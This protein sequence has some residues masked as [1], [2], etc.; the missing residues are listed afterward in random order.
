MVFDPVSAIGL[1][2]TLVQLIDFGRKLLCESHQIHASPT[3]VSSR[4]EELENAAQTLLSLDGNVEHSLQSKG[5]ATSAND[6]ELRRLGQNCHL[7]SLEL[8][9]TLDKLRVAGSKHRKWRSFQQ[10][11][12]SVLS[13]DEIND[14]L[15]RMQESR[16]QLDSHMLACLR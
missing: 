14:L 5:R 4:N 11:F 13:N 8:L 12:K 16:Q 10:A 3:G 6:Q 15:R 7:I 2:G 1:A 9:T